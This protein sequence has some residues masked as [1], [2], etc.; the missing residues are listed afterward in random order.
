M[1][2]EKIIAFAEKQ[3][4]SDAHFVIN[5][6]IFLRIAQ[7]MVPIKETKVTKADLD[8]FLKML[9]TPEEREVL[10]KR[11]QF[12]FLHITKG[13]IRL[14]GNVFAQ[15][16]GYSF[17]FR[18]IPRE[19]RALDS[20]GFPDFLVKR[21]VNIRQ[22]LIL[23]VGPTGQ[24]KTTTLASVLQERM[25]NKM[26]HL[27][28]LEDPIEY[29]LDHG[30]GVVQQREVG[31]DV[32]DFRFGIE[33]ALRED[34][35]VLMVGEMRNLETISSALTMAETGHVVFSTLHTNNG[36]ET[37]T[38]IIDVFSQS[39]QDQIRAQLSS[40]LKLIISQRL[41]PK[42]GGGLTLVYEVLTSNYAVQ[43]YIRQNKIFQI[44]NVLQTDSSGEMIQFEQSLASLY[45]NKVI[46]KEMAEEYSEDVD[47]LNSILK[48]NG[49][50]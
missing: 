30:K 12:D 45:M 44:P 1:D 40:T 22:G 18:L 3:N 50:K 42:D 43:N 2:F 6:P 21:L 41:V 14:R 31:R 16:Y 8:G 32:L 33:A 10:E 5:K 23:V 19:I 38:R 9:I 36:P 35:D 27:I 25:K 24:G 26:E 15:Q 47:Q 48:A 29:V 7:N 39:Q 46:T 17:S 4:A 37:I 49:V 34:P 11:R 20:I 13:G 28:T